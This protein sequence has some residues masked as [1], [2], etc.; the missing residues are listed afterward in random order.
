MPKKIQTPPRSASPALRVGFVPLTDAAPLIMA[1]ELGLFKKFG[2]RVQLSRELGWAT[3]RDKIAYGELEASHALA[4]MPIASTLGLGSLP[5]DCLTALVLN[6]HGN[7][8]TLSNELWK[9]GVRD[10]KSLREEIVRS[11]RE[12]IYTFG[13]VFSFSSHRHLLRR[14]FAAH[15]IDADRDV[16]FVVVPPPQMVANLKAGHLDGF[17]VGE[18]WNSMAVQARAGWI[19]ATSA[20]LDPLHPEKVLM[21]RRDFA[22]GRSGDH[23][24]LVAAVREACEFCD[25]SENAAEIATTLARPEFVGAPAEILRR[26]LSG[27]LDCGNGVTRKVDQ[28]IVFHRNEANEPTGSQAAWALQL[29]RTS[30]LCPQPAKLNYALGR[31]VYRAD[32]YQQAGH[33]FLENPITQNHET[34][35]ELQ[36]V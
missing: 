25:Q 14:W 10:G 2:V 33:Y 19:A 23:L 13:V 17:C 7:A 8:I 4:A 22:E 30:S 31:S 29:V 24:A 12:K 34:P 16:R 1:Q 9:R 11:R 15:G 6:L 5:S 26:A 32:L 21:V 3:V 28:F 27:R 36:A 20:E 18:P 35:S